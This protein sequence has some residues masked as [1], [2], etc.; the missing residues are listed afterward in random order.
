MNTQDNELME[1]K[2]EKAI[3]QSKKLI[4]ETEKRN[5][6]MA[7]VSRQ[8]ENVQS[9]LNSGEISKVEN[10]YV[11]RNGKT[12]SLVTEVV[13]SKQIEKEYK[14]PKYSSVKEK[15]SLMDRF[16]ASLGKVLLGDD[17]PFEG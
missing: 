14:I 9:R 16:Y 6:M 17:F 2:I 13:E 7:R 8:Y 5:K 12:L 10:G 1:E 4:S 15:T 3:N 11:L